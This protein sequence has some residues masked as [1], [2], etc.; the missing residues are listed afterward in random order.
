VCSYL[1]A[2]HSRPPLS[3]SKHSTRRLEVQRKQT[4]RASNPYQT[5][6]AR[7]LQR[8]CTN[9]QHVVQHPQ[10]NIHTRVR[11]QC[12]C[13]LISIRSTSIIHPIASILTCVEPSKIPRQHRAN[14][15]RRILHPIRMRR[16]C[17]L[18]PRERLLRHFLL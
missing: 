6:S 9:V 5:P 7:I 16:L 18:V 14:E 8:G 11:I 12:R 17:A 1:P 4:Q 15:K 10:P 3:P 13:I 2:P